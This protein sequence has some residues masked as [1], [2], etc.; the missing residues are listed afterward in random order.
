MP[1]ILS[2]DRIWVYTC[3]YVFSNANH[4]SWSGLQ[5]VC[6]GVKEF[7]FRSAISTTVN[8]LIEAVASIGIYIFYSQI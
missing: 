1:V 5:L 2:W 7:V 4:L 6:R 8:S 3:I